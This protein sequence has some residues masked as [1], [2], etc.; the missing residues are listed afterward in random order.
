MVKS[1]IKSGDFF[2]GG[3]REPHNHNNLLWFHMQSEVDKLP[4]C[5]SLNNSWRH[6]CSVA[7]TE[8]TLLGYQLCNQ[9]GRFPSNCKACNISLWLY[10][11]RIWSGSSV[12]LGTCRYTALKLTCLI[13]HYISSHLS[14]SRDI[15]A[16][17]LSPNSQTTKLMQALFNVVFW[18][19][20]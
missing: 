15:L 6:W 1:F 3:H 17:K 10:A 9:I 14:P 7:I 5:Y 19:S 20:S 8:H 13:H 4:S 18:W 12:P 16:R 2:A 11:D